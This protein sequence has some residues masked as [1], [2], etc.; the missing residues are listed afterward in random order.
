MTQTSRFHDVTSNTDVHFAETFS[1]VHLDGVDAGSLNALKVYAST[2][3]AMTV[4]VPTGIAWVQGR[5]YKNDA[6][7][8]KTIEAADASYTRYDR[9]VLRSTPCTLR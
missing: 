7:V 5:W 8:T 4:E 2:P 9:I 3:N 1:S 6:V